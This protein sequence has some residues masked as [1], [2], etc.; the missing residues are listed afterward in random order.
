MEEIQSYKEYLNQA[1]DYEEKEEL[2]LAEDFYIK[3]EEMAIVEIEQKLAKTARVMFYFRQEMFLKAEQV[4]REII[5]QYPD[6]Y[7]GHHLLFLIW[8]KRKRN[9]DLEQHF[10]QIQ[11]QFGEQHQ[12]LSD[13]WEVLKTLEGKQDITRNVIRKLF[14][15]YN[16][17][18]AAFAEMLFA[19]GEEN[20]D[21]AAL[22]AV[23]ILDAE[24]EMPGFLF[25]QTLYMHIFILH[26]Q[27][28]G[29]PDKNA[30]AVM[31]QSAEQCIEW[32][33]KMGLYT[34]EMEKALKAVV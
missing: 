32:F 30:K 1:A 9:T 21:R 24:K 29:K 34:D 10:L 19:M 28:G 17:M 15:E 16:D 8:Q 4:A 20:F 25:Y 22:I 12:Y 18:N 13:Y 31:K 23:L 26:C 6:S 14:E 27:M 33:G 11:E 3:A 2:F 7:Q 5:K